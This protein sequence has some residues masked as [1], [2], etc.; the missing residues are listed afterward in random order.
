MNYTH[1]TMKDFGRF[2]RPQHR[3]YRGGKSPGRIKKQ[4]VF[5]ISLKVLIFGAL[6]LGIL[7]VSFV[8]TRA[9]SM[10]TLRLAYS[11]LDL[12]SGFNHRNLRALDTYDST[13]SLGHHSTIE[14]FGSTTPNHTDDHVSGGTSTPATATDDHHPTDDHSSGGG[15]HSTTFRLFGAIAKLNVLIATMSVLVIVLAVQIVEYM[16]HSLRRMTYDTAFQE[17][18]QSIEQELMGVGCTAL[19]FTILVNTTSFLPLEWFHA[20]EYAG[21]V[22]CVHYLCCCTYVCAIYIYVY[23]HIL[24]LACI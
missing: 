21:N 9:V 3:E 5:G 22:I 15:S 14:T 7:L 11:S 16:F 19:M 4:S 1:M 10:S 23:V 20:L 18:V 6:S 17:M 24:T 12:T 13:F 8:L 2:N